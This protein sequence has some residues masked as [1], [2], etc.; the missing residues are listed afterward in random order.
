MAACVVR[1]VVSVSW[2]ARQGQ[3]GTHTA[4]GNTTGGVD[5]VQYHWQTGEHFQLEQAT[6]CGILMYKKY[7]ERSFRGKSSLLTLFLTFGEGPSGILSALLPKKL[8]M[9]DLQT[10]KGQT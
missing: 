8:L 10:R 3:Y 5:T 4:W 1:V 9:T 7:I 2:L 6:I